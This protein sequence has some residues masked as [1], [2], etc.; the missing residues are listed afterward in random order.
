MS[1]PQMPAAGPSNPLPFYTT[2]TTTLHT[3]ISATIGA[4]LHLDFPIP[5]TPIPTSYTTPPTPDSPASKAYPYGLPILVL[6]ELDAVVYDPLGS[7]VVSTVTTVQAAPGDAPEAVDDSGKM[8]RDGDSSNA[9]SDWTEAERAGV[10]VGMVVAV[11][12]TMGMLLWCCRR[13]RASE[14]G[15]ETKRWTRMREEKWWK[16]ESRKIGR[17]EK[18]K[19]VLKD[20]ELA[21]DPGGKAVEKEVGA[22]SSKRRQDLPRIN[23]SRESPGTVL[24]D[25]MPTGEPYQMTGALQI[26]RSPAPM[27]LRAPTPAV[28]VGVEKVQKPPLGTEASRDKTSAYRATREEKR[29]ESQRVYGVASVDVWPTIGRAMEYCWLERIVVYADT[30]S[31][32]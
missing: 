15:G 6:T 13:N 31:T 2:T 21:S 9:W 3:T 20:L 27:Q 5:I 24:K 22:R 29:R 26:P 17:A 11:V 23:F 10:M 18:K 7:K 30:W 1:P 16:K 25:R 28:Q 12:I 19:D 4:V 8:D 14:R 32:L